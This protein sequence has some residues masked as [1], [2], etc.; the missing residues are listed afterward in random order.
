MEIL[1]TFVKADDVAG[2]IVAPSVLG[3]MLGLFSWFYYN[4]NNRFRSAV[5]AVIGV[6]LVL[7]AAAVVRA[8]ISGEFDRTYHEV[9]ITDMSAFDTSKYEVVEQRGKIFVVQEVAR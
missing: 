4:E 1:H 5:C 2:L 7:F 9:L 6:V 8:H 3:V